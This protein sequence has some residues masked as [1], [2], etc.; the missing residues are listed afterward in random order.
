MNEYDTTI[1]GFQGSVV[2]DEGRLVILLKSTKEKF[3]IVSVVD[4]SP[5]DMPYLVFNMQKC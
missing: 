4:K 2:D 5:D 1:A 3:E